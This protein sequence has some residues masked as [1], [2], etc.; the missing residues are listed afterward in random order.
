MSQTFLDENLMTWEAFASSG[1][2]GLSEQPRIVFNCLSDP[3][4][5]PRYLQRSGGEAE[6]EGGVFAS[7]DA[8]LLEL[9]R[10]SHPLE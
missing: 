6:A 7:D 4:I 1:N 8:T 3:G 5:A 2:Y 9:L 10:A